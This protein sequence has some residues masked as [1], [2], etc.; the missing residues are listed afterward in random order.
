MLQISSPSALVIKTSGAV[1]VTEAATCRTPSTGTVTAKES[2]VLAA[3]DPLIVCATVVRVPTSF[4]KPSESLYSFS[5][6]AAKGPAE[7]SS[8]G[9]F[10]RSRNRALRPRCRAIPRN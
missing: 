3:S 10:M 8:T 7:G 2:T 1:P 9:V 4:A 6:V 5:T